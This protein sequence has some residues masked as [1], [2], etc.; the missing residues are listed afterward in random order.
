MNLRI[1]IPKITYNILY[2]F[3]LKILEGV[4][5]EAAA[6]F[7]S[8]LF[9]LSWNLELFILITIKFYHESRSDSSFFIGL[10]SFFI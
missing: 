8:W 3:S 7:L 2:Y 10:K 6:T 1:E 5:Y 9:S 4:F